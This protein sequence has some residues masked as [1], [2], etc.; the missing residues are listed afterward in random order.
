MIGNLF[1]LKTMKTHIFLL[2]FLLHFQVIL[3]FSPHFLCIFLRLFILYQFSVSCSSSSCMIH[4]LYCLLFWCNHYF[5][6]V[7]DD[8]VY[9]SRQINFEL[10]AYNHVK[11]ARKIL[12]P[13]NS[14]PLFK[15][16]AKTAQS[17][18]Q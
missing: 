10:L 17:F 4:F 6:L 1:S 3:S 8:L 2:L 5:D 12:N 13:S 14:P 15:I 18:Q 11:K 7:L 16:F 9:M